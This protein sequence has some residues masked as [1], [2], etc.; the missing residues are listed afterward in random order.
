[1]KLSTS[2]F[3]G[4][5]ATTAVVAAAVPGVHAATFGEAEINQNE[6]IAVAAP[7]GQGEHQLLIIG[8][9]PGKQACWSESGSNPVIIDPLLV[10]FDFTG[11]CD[12]KTDANG[13]SIRIDGEDQ[14]LNYSLRIR[15]RNGDLV[16]VGSPPPNSQGQE[17][18]IGRAGG[19]T[20][21][22]AKI[23]LDSE[24]RFT[25]RT[26]EKKA[27]GHIY[28]TK[29]I[30]Q[31]PFPDVAN[32]IYLKEIRAAVS[33]K[34]ISGFAEDNTFRP[35]ASLTREQLVSIVLGALPN[36]PGVTL[37][38]PTQTSANPY[39]DV[40]ASRWSAAKI[41]FAKEKNIVQGYPEGDFRPTRTVSRAE[42]MA[43]LKKAAEYARTL[44][45]FEPTLKPTQAAVTFSDTSTHWATAVISE[46]SGYC[47][48]ASPLNERG[49]AFMPN[50][51]S[52]RNYAAAA[53]VRMLTCARDEKS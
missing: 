1:M 11:I 29:G 12:R 27:L 45:G 49:Q 40:L 21:G 33:Q 46:M 2:P 31:I 36:V 23:N 17:I 10:K 34:F 35:L 28:L 44:R 8:Q 48:V 4:V 43:V 30:S 50:E 32:D 53:T 24:W 7:F 38:V 39:P 47:G 13:Y 3:W 25:K 52:Q 41:A 9:V 22:F 42:M 5:L 14:A 20:D 18:E 37:D 51:A 15:R 16:L 6:Y 26:F 19:V